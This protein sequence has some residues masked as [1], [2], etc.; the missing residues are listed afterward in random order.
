MTRTASQIIVD[1]VTEVLTIEESALES[2]P[3]AD[4]ELVHGIVKVADRLVVL[5]NLDGVFAGATLSPA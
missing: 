3:V 1:E 2:A 4:G 5:L